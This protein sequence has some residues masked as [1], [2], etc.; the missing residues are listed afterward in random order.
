MRIGRSNNIEAL[1]GYD[2]FLQR[3]VTGVSHD[4]RQTFMN[5]VAVRCGDEGVAGFIPDTIGLLPFDPGAKPEPA[6]RVQ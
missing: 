5:E 1:I 3:C 6:S 4:R 2:L